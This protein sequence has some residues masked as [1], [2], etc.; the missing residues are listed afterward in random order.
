MK[1]KTLGI[2]LLISLG[3]ALFAAIIESQSA[4]LGSFLYTVSGIGIL[5]FGIW[6]GIV[7]KRDK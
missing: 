3:V 7:L 5:F 6:G 1:N 4:D 2:G